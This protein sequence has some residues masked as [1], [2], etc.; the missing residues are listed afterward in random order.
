MF[1]LLEKQLKQRCKSLEGRIINLRT[2]K[3]T[4]EDELYDLKS[5]H[6]KLTRLRKVEEEEIAHKIRMRDEQVGIE[7]EKGI[8]D[9]ERKAD[10]KVME[11]KGAYQD[12]LTKQLEDR[13]NEL[14]EMYS[15]ILTRLP[16]VTV[17]IGGTQVKKKK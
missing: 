11:V 3:D 5:D 16:E 12:K 9:A 1:G 14:R 15:E 13:G 2:E 7:K 8:A 10:E 6:E 4:V 17:D